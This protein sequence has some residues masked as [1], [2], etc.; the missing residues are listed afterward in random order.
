[1]TG[2]GSRLAVLVLVG[3]LAAACTDNADPK[4]LPSPS[5]SPSASPSSSG[6]VAPTLPAEAKGKS[7]ASAKAFVRYWVAVLNYSGPA[8]DTR[9]LRSLSAQRCIDCDAIAD[10]IEQVSGAGGAITGKGWTVRNVRIID[11][12]GTNGPTLDALVDV[13]PQRVIPKAG[14]KPRRFPGG[15]RLKTFWLQ[16]QHATWSVSRLDQSQ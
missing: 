16:W 10:F 8:G 11:G 5:A 9:D 2:L 14:A 12:A 4:P 13:S 6:P 1:V 15:K 3:V 7:A